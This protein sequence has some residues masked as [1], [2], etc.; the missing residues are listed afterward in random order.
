[1]RNKDRF[2]MTEDPKLGITEDDEDQVD[3]D[4]DKEL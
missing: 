1:M 3:D 4:F 2:D